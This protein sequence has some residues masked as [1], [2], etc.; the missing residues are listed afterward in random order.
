MKTWRTQLKS[1]LNEKPLILPKS[2]MKDNSEGFYYQTSCCTS[3]YDTKYEAVFERTN[4]FSDKQ[5]FKKFESYLLQS[6]NLY[7]TSFI[8]QKTKVKFQ[9][10]P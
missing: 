5:D 1:W 3:T 7:A 9:N 8:Y 4:E 2:S 10:T 6:K